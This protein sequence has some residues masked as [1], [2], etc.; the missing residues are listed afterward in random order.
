M[1]EMESEIVKRERD[2]LIKET[3]V[4]KKERELLKKKVELNVRTLP[5][6]TSTIIV[7]LFGLT[8]VCAGS[9]GRGRADETEAQQDECG[10]L[11]EGVPG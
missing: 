4:L 10:K 8:P 1:L 5:I 2:L 9:R 7:L 6:A 3:E 11:E